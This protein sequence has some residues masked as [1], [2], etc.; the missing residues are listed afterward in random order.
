[1]ELICRLSNK[2]VQ[3]LRLRYFGMLSGEL[4]NNKQNCLKNK[5]ESIFIFLKL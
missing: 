5:T 1:M 4:S 2:V 3:V